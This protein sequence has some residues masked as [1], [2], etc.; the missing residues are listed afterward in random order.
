MELY[1]SLG[2]TDIVESTKDWGIRAT[3][4]KWSTDCLEARSPFAYP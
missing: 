2:L 4:V 1:V 3:N